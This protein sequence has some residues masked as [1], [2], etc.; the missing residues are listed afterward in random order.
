MAAQKGQQHGDPG[1]PE[2]SQ[3]RP[4]VRSL[5]MIGLVL[6]VLAALIETIT[7]GT[8]RPI[9]GGLALLAIAAF[10][11]AGVGRLTEPESVRAA[12]AQAA[13]GASDPDGRSGPWQEDDAPWREDADGPWQEEGGDGG[14][15]GWNE[16][17]GPW[18]ERG[19]PSAPAER[20]GGWQGAP[21]GARAG[22]RTQT[23][24]ATRVPGQRRERG[25]KA[26]QVPERTFPR[27]SELSEVV[28][29]PTP[30]HY[31]HRGQAPYVRR[32][33]ADG[34]LAALLNADSQPFPF[35]VVVGP[36]KAGKSR[37]VVE[38]V[39]SVLGGRDPGVFVPGSGEELAEV[40]REEEA[41]PRGR[42]PWVIWLDDVTAADLVHLSA[43]TLDRAARHAMIVAS[44]TDERWDQVLDSHG[45]VAAT[46]K[47]ALRRATKVPLDFELTV[48]E[49]A[50]AEQLYPQLQINASI[51]EALIGGDQLVAKFR[52]GRD[53]EPAGYT[54]V[55]AAV[56][57]RRA[58]LNRPLT[59]SELRGLYP[60]YLRRVR[61][62]LDPTTA[63]F[64]EGM[65]WATEPVASEVSLLSQV[66][67]GAGSAGGAG[68][69]GVA[70]GALGSSL[71]S[72]TGPGTRAKPTENPDGALEVLDYV[73]AIEEGRHG[74]E[75][76]PVFDAMWQELIAAVPPDD[77]FDIGI[78]ASLR[79]NQSAAEL[80]FRKVLDLDHA[81][82]APRAA[83]N[84]GLLLRERGDVAGAR[85]AFQKAIDSGHPD[86]MPRAANNLGALL[87]QQGD[88]SGARGA[89]QKAIDSGHTDVVPR[90]ANDLGSLL[91]GQGDV[92]GA[93]TA[94]QRAVDSGHTD[95]VPSA[96]LNLGMLLKDQGDVAGAETAY[97]RAMGSGDPEVVP[98]AALNLGSL[99]RE[100][101]DMAGARTAYQRAV[102]SGHAEVV[103]VAA[104]NLGSLLREQGDMAGARTAY[105]RAVDSDHPGVMP[106]A[107]LNLGMLLKDQGDPEG[108][109]AAYQRAVDSGDVDVVPMAALY[110]GSLLKDQGDLVGAETAFQRAVDSGHPDVAPMAANNLG[111]LLT[112]EADVGGARA[113][114]ELAV[115]S[116]HADV[117]PMA[118]NN[119]GVLLTEEAEVDDARAAYQ[120][121][122][123]SG[124][125]DVAPMAALNLG[126]LLDAQGDVGG[127]RS[128]YE[129]AVD[130][131]HADVVSVAAVNLGTLLRDQGDVA[132]ARAAFHLAIDSGFV[133][134]APVSAGHL[135]VLL[136]G[137]GGS[138]NARPAARIG[139][140]RVRETAALGARAGE[141][142][143]DVEGGDDLGT[144]E[145]ME[146]GLG[147]DEGPNGRRT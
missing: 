133:D 38:A 23:Q 118:A 83:N 73:V 103:P 20:A 19:E 12:R 63:L 55:Q 2:E 18:S 106:V 104:L 95:V 46:A 1:K 27:L 15:G 70:H 126:L 31:A 59:E 142:G 135:R 45:D 57:A 119:L 44:M 146:E 10:V 88:V 89:Y 42:Q 37:T 120:V 30:T 39:R 36:S 136:A 16:G 61:I 35:V 32:P 91:R 49:R 144:L 147:E 71:G 82:E 130:S 107:A 84:L 97:E 72:T 29:G 76:R 54:I 4:W 108:A 64:E 138:V 99:L 96:A 93:R 109:E 139:A 53:R 85:A 69:A 114:Y 102:D 77:A 26:P 127:A 116:E 125:A 47:A 62:D 3:G 112:E 78:G 21:P 41:L 143:A 14:E 56:D 9:V 132:G 134:I 58:G 87:R 65:A 113:A 75:A 52:A 90:A 101:G 6:L 111:V 43:D 81:G 94:Y 80:A 137:Q 74:Q 66:G 145:A 13:D 98:V 124:H 121:A 129:L 17:E 115:R 140:D 100:Q 8:Q 105:Q 22:A 123:D 34:R 86:V 7:A 40:L 25:R 92:A 131:G 24:A 67:G 28:L 48:R 60:L 50:E 79:G 51:G 68:G 141:S 117:A 33:A 11:V 5:G 122:V 110:R 128:A